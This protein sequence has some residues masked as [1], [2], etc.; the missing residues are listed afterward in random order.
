MTKRKPS[1]F[2]VGVES[3]RVE[4]EDGAT[5]KEPVIDVREPKA[6]RVAKS[7]KTSDRTRAMSARHVKKSSEMRTSAPE[8]VAVKSG[9]QAVG[10]DTH[11]GRSAEH[12]RRIVA[13]QASLTQAEQ[14][15][16]DAVAAAREAGDPWTL[17]GA[18]L[19]VSKQAAA[20]RF[21]TR[22]PKD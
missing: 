6:E 9:G 11:E 13:A 7:S 16:R 15:L 14:D 21:G 3:V 5:L 1:E 22:Q 18:A 20:Q 12:F 4:R 2:A 8:F 19:G 17:I 10:A